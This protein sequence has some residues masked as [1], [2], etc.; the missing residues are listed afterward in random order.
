[1][2][3]NIYNKRQGG[4]SA[5]A[6]FGIHHHPEGSEFDR[7]VMYF[8]KWPRIVGVEKKKKKK[9]NSFSAPLHVCVC[10]CA[11]KE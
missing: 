2:F 8:R 9:N 3:K 6:S 10:V 11:K 1:M 5:Q 4:C 7:S